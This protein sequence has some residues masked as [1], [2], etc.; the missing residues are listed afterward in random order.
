MDEKRGSSTT[1]DQFAYF[2]PWGG[3]TAVYK[4]GW[5]TVKWEQLPSSLYCDSGLV[6]I[7]GEL[8]AVGGYEGSH[9]RTNK[10]VTLQQG[11]WVE[12]YPPMNTARSMTTVVSTSDGNYIFVIGGCGDCNVTTIELFHKR[13]RNWYELAYLP[14]P[15]NVLQPRY[16]VI[17][18]M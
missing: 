6:I 8:N 11:Q 14:P 12:H 16:V 5:S 10:L 7:D 13:T 18:Y 17:N 1:D 2:T 15:S 9:H 3:S 4:Y